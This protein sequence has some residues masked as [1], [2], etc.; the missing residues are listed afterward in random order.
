MLKQRPPKFDP[1]LIA[2]LV[3]RIITTT[4]SKRNRGSTNSRVSQSAVSEDTH[5][6]SIVAVGADGSKSTHTN[7]TG[8][9][10]KSAAV[11]IGGNNRL[12][13]LQRAAAKIRSETNVNVNTPITSGASI[14]SVSTSSTQ[15]TTINNVPKTNNSA[16]ESGTIVNGETGDAIL[17]FLSG[18][19]SIEKVNKALR[20]R[21]IL[22]SLK[23]QVLFIYIH[24]AF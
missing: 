8:S 5:V 11:K 6:A 2:E 1:E 7:A 20:Q 19:Q 15:T 9:F 12:G 14:S 16:A 23:A 3:I 10:D 13:N 24:V 4:N 18:I 21:G 22:P 17:V